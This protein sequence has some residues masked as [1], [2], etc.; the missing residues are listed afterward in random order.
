M[1]AVKKEEDE[2]RPTVRRAQ[3]AMQKEDYKRVRSQEKTRRKSAML[4][5]I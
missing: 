5:Y 3:P 4:R 1:T 2:E